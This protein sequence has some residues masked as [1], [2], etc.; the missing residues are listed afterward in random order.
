M[1]QTTE[2]LQLALWAE[3]KA[4]VIAV[5]NF[6][7]ENQGSGESQ[8]VEVAS[9]PAVQQPIDPKSPTVATM[10]EPVRADAGDRNTTKAAADKL[11][12]EDG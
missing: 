1:S 9:P 4:K 10:S 7:E 8:K 3:E 5:M 11:E 12:Y 2:G 6:V